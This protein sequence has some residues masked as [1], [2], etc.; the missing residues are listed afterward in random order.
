MVLLVMMETIALKEIHAMQELALEKR[1]KDAVSLKRLL[2]H[3]LPANLTLHKS[4][5]L[6]KRALRNKA[7]YKEEQPVM[8]ALLL[9]KNLAA[10]V[11]AEPHLVQ[12]PSPYWY[13]LL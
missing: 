13:L 10:V 7:P 6:N 9:P 3:L 11:A 1:L 5:A 12:L 8:Q 2:N 4:Q